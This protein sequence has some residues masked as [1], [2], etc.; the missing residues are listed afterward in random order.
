MPSS[1][2]TYSLPRS[3]F[4]LERSPQDLLCGRV[5]RM[6]GVVRDDFLAAVHHG[7]VQYREATRDAEVTDDA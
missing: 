6:P 5:L 1:V 2:D 4:R 3:T 7:V